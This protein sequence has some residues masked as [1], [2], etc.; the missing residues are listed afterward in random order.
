MPAHSHHEMRE[1]GWREWIGLPDL[2][3]TT[4]KAKLDTGARTSA[5]HATNIETHKRDGE[6]WV[7]FLVPLARLPKRRKCTARILDERE[8]R[9][10]SGRSERRLI[11]G[12][13]LVFGHRHWKIE[14]S[15][16]NRMQ[17]EFEVILGRTALRGHGL[18]VNPG[19]SYLM[20]PP[21]TTLSSVQK[22]ESNVGLL[23]TLN[24]DK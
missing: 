19:K 24:L 23:R 1:I 13:N 10:T 21:V 14:L 15:L 11:I 12:T 8:I 2:G 22:D 6:F 3:I 7:E 17:M 20:G 18:L 9:N 5:L 16:A 4:I